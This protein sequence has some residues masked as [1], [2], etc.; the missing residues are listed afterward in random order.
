MKQISGEKYR[1]IQINGMKN[2]GIIM[3]ELFRQLEPH[4]S[5]DRRVEDEFIRLLR[6]LQYNMLKKI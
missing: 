6:V 2:V 1:S 3:T 5:F 4:Y